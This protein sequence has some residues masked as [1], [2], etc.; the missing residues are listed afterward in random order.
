MKP[1][2]LVFYKYRPAVKSMHAGKF[3]HDPYE[4]MEID[5]DGD[6]MLCGCQ[7]HMPYVIG[8]VYKDTI[9]DIWQNQEAA[10]VRDSVVRGEFAYCNWSCPKL[11]YLVDL[12]E[13]IPAVGNFPRSIK[14]D[15]D[16]SCN[17]KCPSC[18]EHLIQEK[19]NY[20]IQKQKQIFQ[21]VVDYALSHPDQHF[22]IFPTAS[23]ELLAS[24]SGL[25]FLRSMQNYPY[26]NLEII[27]SSNGT[28]LWHHQELINHVIDRVGI[29]VSIDAATPETYAQ[30]RGGNWDDLLKGL[31]LYQG[32]IQQLNFVVQQAN[33]QEIE[34]IA[35]F[36]ESLNTRVDYQKLENW[37]HWNPDWWH[38][39]NALDRTRDYY[40]D[41]ITALTN[42][43]TRFP[44]STFAA[45]LVNLMNKK[46]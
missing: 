11:N 13:V 30:V 6:V 1:E 38:E 3:C 21:E 28:L 44:R 2:V 5:E 45:G 18:R 36:A 33:W 43:R 32:K 4:I 8:N 27:F 29:S 16:R 35:K 7:F 15:L 46:I 37:G 42:V 25:E 19:D 12:P 24:H 34:S 26:P 22:K 9:S 40:D 39:N 14:I 31:H 23:G 17:L 41:V 20:K 10:K